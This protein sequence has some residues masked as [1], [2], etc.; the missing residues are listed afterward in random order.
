MSAPKDGNYYQI[1]EI[2]NRVDKNIS[3]EQLATIIEEVTE[4]VFGN[5]Y[6]RKGTN[7]LEI[8]KKIDSLIK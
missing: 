1:H 7:I 5:K 4:K 6:F 2:W 3:T 8:A